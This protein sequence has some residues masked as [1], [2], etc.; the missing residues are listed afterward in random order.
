MKKA[1]MK[2]IIIKFDNK[3]IFLFLNYDYL[4][5]KKK[6]KIREKRKTFFFNLFC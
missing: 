1:K 2:S 4:K 5:K 3:N 6:E